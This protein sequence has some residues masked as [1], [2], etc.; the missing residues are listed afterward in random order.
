MYSTFN[1]S[2]FYSLLGLWLS[3]PGLVLVS[4]VRG[5]ES[6]CFV[7]VSGSC[8]LEGTTG[9]RGVIVVPQHQTTNKTK[10][11]LYF[12]TH[13]FLHCYIVIYHFWEEGV[14]DIRSILS[15]CTWEN[16]AIQ[17]HGTYLGFEQ[18]PGKEGISWQ[19]PIVKYLRRCSNWSHI[20]Q[21]LYFATAAYNTF[22]ASVL[23]FIAQLEVPSPEVFG[24]RKGL[25]SAANAGACHLATPGG[26]LFSQ[27]VLR[28]N[29]L[30]PVS[31]FFC[32]GGQI[33]SVGSP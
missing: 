31:D 15:N 10:T 2:R 22:I 16:L 9:R 24:C 21:G 7:E 29:S 30:I 19:K 8:W 12:H 33:A 20:H 11:W 17:L 26:S 5:S 32:Q 4:F 3:A 27:R 18:G 13:I 23:M 28:A 1:S 14:E 6:S 25:T